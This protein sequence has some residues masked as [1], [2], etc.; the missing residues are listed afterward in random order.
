MSWPRGASPGARSCCVLR[1]AAPRARPAAAPS[2]AGPA[3]SP[4]HPAAAAAAAEAEA[5]EDPD[6]E[7]AHSDASGGVAA[8]GNTS[9]TLTVF[10]GLWFIASKVLTSTVSSSVAL[11]RD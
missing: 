10:K 3:R 2:P 8:P 9:H 5:P 6:G 1:S 11:C 7:G 4:G